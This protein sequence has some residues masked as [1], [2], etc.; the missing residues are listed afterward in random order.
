VGVRDVVDAVEQKTKR[1]QNVDEAGPKACRAPVKF[2]AKGHEI[3][4]C[5]GSAQTR[6]GNLE[7]KKRAGH[8][9]ALCDG[10]LRWFDGDVHQW[11]GRM[12]NSSSP[13]ESHRNGTP[14]KL[15]LGL[16]RTEKQESSF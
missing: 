6:T 10:D 1:K 11:G 12:P 13:S 5:S 16:K 4:K 8:L 14:R 2:P 3:E 7:Q 15:F 9:C